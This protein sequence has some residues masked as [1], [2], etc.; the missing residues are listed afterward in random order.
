MITEQKASDIFYEAIRV[1]F[2][3]KR[4]RK[5]REREKLCSAK[6]YFMHFGDDDHLLVTNPA[7][8]GEMCPLLGRCPRW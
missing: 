2:S 6:N 8:L 3:E 7:H 4:R 5:K 1:S